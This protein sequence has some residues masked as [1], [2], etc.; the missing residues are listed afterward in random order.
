LKTI[1]VRHKGKIICT[2]MHC[3]NLLTRSLGLMLRKKQSAL[4]ELP[5]ESRAF[6]GIHTFFMLFPIDVA[7]L[8]SKC[9]IVSV[10]QRIRPCRIAQAEKPAKYILETPAGAISLKQGQK[11]AF[12]HSG[13]LRNL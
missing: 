6:A 13:H 8:D 9:V 2:A 4:L 7:W 11:L 12:L 1:S 5:A 3:N 10:K